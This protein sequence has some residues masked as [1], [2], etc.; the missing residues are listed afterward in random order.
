MAAMD[1]MQ[2]LPP[3]EPVAWTGIGLVGLFALWRT[4]VVPR[5]DAWRATRA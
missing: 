5:L 4:Q 1:W 3:V 2:A